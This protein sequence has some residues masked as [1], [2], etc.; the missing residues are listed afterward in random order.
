MEEDKK[1]EEDNISRLNTEIAALHEQRREGVL[2]DVVFKVVTACG[3][4]EMNATFGMK[5]TAG[6][7]MMDPEAEGEREIDMIQ[8]W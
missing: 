4:A 3:M 5:D 2:V 7:I 1:V 6:T 8:K